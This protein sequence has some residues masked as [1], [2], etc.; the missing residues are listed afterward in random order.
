LNN[1]QI[2][3]NYQLKLG[4]AN[5]GSPLAGTGSALSFGSKVVAGTYTVIASNGVTGCTVPMSGN[6]VIT[7]T[8]LPI[9]F[10]VTG[11]GFYCSGGFGVSVGLSGSQIGVSYQLRINGVNTGS[12]VPGTLSAISFGQQTVP[13]TYTVL[14]TIVSTGCNSIMAGNAIVAI[15]PLP[16]AHNVTGGGAYCSGGSGLTV[17]LSSSELGVNY[18]LKLDGTDSGTAIAGT[19]NSINF[20]NKIS[21]G[22]YTVEATNTTTGCK[23]TM[24]GSVTVTINPLPAL[25]SVTGGGAYCSGGPGAVVGLNNSEIGINYQ[26]LIGG[27]N[28]GTPIAGTGSAISF[29]AQ[30]AVGT[31]TVIATNASTGCTSTMTGSVTVTTNALPLAYSVTGGGSYC[32]G[33]SGVAVGL[34]NSQVGVNY[35]LRLDLVDTGSPVAGT[36][37]AI[38]FGSK[39]SAGTYTVVATSA[40]T[41]CT[42]IMTGSVAVSISPLPAIY[43]VT[44]GGTDCS[45]GSGVA[46]GL[47]NSQVGVNYQLQIGGVNTGSPIVGTGGSLNF[48]TQI[49]AGT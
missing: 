23:A 25:F 36:G 4:G 13:G 38:S 32:N 2:G 44:G 10:N 20:G 41:S 47:S 22:V 37:S 1:S 8:P 28:T 18:Q 39:M 42:S 48:G 6:V 29:G 26:L 5:T 7:L 14:A 31:Y 24:T 16:A 33:G 45:G 19:G 17:G 21:A 9:S 34:S 46:V 43:A 35:Q 3:I 49:V 11:G 12:S 27:A 30:T 15:N 40:S